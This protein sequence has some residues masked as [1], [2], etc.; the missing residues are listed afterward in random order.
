MLLLAGVTVSSQ[1]PNL[2]FT[3][4]T[5]GQLVSGFKTVAVYLDDS[6]HA[7]GARFRHERT[8]F[9]LD[10][11]QIQSVPQAF[12]W[13]TTYPTS[14]MGE[15][16]TQEHLLLGKGNKGRALGSQEPMSLVTSSAFTEQWMTCYHFYA[17][18]GP[19][20]F[21][22]HFEHTMDA[23]LHPDYSQ[24]E[25]RREVRNFGVSADPKNGSLSLEEKGT[26]YNEMVTSMDQAP[27]R[28]FRAAG[29]AA[30][31]PEHP[32]S[33]NSGGTP[34]ALRAIKPSDIERFHAQHY[35]LGNMGAIASLPKE[36]TLPSALAR[37]NATLNRLEPEP[38][39]LPVM[40]ADQL[41]AP[42]PAP[43]G[44]IE[45]VEYP[46]RNGQQPGTA[47]LLWPADRKL[48]LRDQTLL[49]LFLNNVAGGPD[50]NL[51]KRLIDSRTREADFGA[52]G[53]SAYV[54]TDQGA[55][56]Y[57]M[58]QDV[59]VARMNDADMA[60]LRSKVLDEF[61]RIAAYPDGSP[62]LAQFNQRLKSRILQTRRDLSKFVNSPPGFG[63]R[64]IGAE[65]IMHLYQ[66]NREPGFRKSV[67]EKEDLAAI[68]K[69]IASD[70]NI[71]REYL[72]QWKITGVT[73]Y[74]EAAKPNPQLLQQEEKERDQRAAAEVARLKEQYHA[75]SDA[76]AIRKYRDEYDAATAQ[77]RP[78]GPG[79]HPAQVRR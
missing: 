2:A 68:E 6:D 15:P 16:H 3:N 34:E 29:L 73:P 18:A 10:L 76:E 33:Y 72:T 41:P 7:M 11:L 38:K 27:N 69:L 62:D 74:V 19:E 48:N 57:V 49:E 39:K 9:T 30:Y 67:T 31:G 4:L 44:R 21:Y 58:F 50:T 12:I 22:N 14:N 40:T 26:V 42:Q 54:D 64:G 65:W 71:W 45:F 47:M 66:L 70:R 13:V 53:V 77:D 78:C 8:G 23:L 25:V 5:E 46:F 63:F 59:P 56:V 61:A 60:S 43:A 75:T 20:V 37:L 52:K 35:F 36:M 28:L 1:Q 24:E 17:S 79:P 32:L 55:P 51:Y